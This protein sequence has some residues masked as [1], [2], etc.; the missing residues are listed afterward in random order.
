MPTQDDI[1]QQQ[2][3]LATHRRTLAVYLNQ[4]A[5]HG[6]TH[7]PPEI[8]HGIAES[9]AAIHRSKAVLQGWGVQVENLPND[10]APQ[11]RRQPPPTPPPDDEEQ[12][13]HLRELLRAH[14]SRLRVLELQRATQGIH[15]PPQVTIE[16]ESIRVDIARVKA[17][18]V[19]NMP[20]IT[21]AALRQLRQ[22]A[23]TAFYAQ[24]WELAE[25]LLAQMLAANLD[26]AD[27]QAKQA[28]ASRQLDLRALYQVI[29]Y[30][31]DAGH[32]R[33]ALAALDDLERQEPGYPDLDGLRV[34]AERS[35]L[36]DDV[37]TARVRNDLAA[38]GRA[39]DALVSAYPDDT[40]LV[41]LD[42]LL[43]EYPGELPI[44][45][46][47]LLAHERHRRKQPAAA[48]D[49]A[50]HVTSEGV[51]Q[52]HPVQKPPDPAM[53][54]EQVRLVAPTS[55][56]IS[57]STNLP[58]PTEVSIIA[59]R[60]DYQREESGRGYYSIW[61]EI[62][63]G[64]AQPIYDPDVTVTFYDAH[65]NVVPLEAGRGFSLMKVIEAHGLGPFHFHVYGPCRIMDHI[66]R[67]AI[68]A[69]YTTDTNG[70]MPLPFEKHYNSDT[71][72]RIVVHN[73]YDYDIQGLRLIVT[74]YE[75]ESVYEAWEDYVGNK[76]Y[77]DGVWTF[78]VR[79]SAHPYR[80][81][82]EGRRS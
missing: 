77:S 17:E 30:L 48:P 79:I 5:A 32:W 46:K 63:N 9:R 31:R 66:V 51:E 56:A 23:L 19:V 24:E 42:S 10:E 44:H 21:R 57:A 2:V 73:P 74:I 12:R 67:F 4:L 36:L 15:T 70:W 62:V 54:A 8:F 64:L 61:G 53:R 49:R 25:D 3:L 52:K 45:P 28:E 16:I 68:T 50:A 18:L 29:L 11:E 75:A 7:A 1:E 72:E 26:D 81:Q 35:K 41:L 37:R 65:N 80:I 78:H 47:T 71:N 14:Q 82:A 38:V 6:E 76:V 20:A 59:G 27:V 33:A 13:R 69:S 34:W 22:Q 60:S 58:F 43:A 39:L 40:A 55:A